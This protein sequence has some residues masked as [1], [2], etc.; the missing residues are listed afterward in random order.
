MVTANS[1][2]LFSTRLV[3]VFTWVGGIQ[4]VCSTVCWD[5]LE[6]QYMLN[7]GMRMPAWMHRLFTEQAH[8]IIDVA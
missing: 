1:L 7:A 2:E 5:Q 8:I 3:D 4:M 6:K